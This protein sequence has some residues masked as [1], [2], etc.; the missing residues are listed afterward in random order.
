MEL[1]HLRYFCVV[2]EEL[3]LTCAAERLHTPDM[4]VR[5]YHDARLAE[6]R[7][8]AE[9][10]VDVVPAAVCRL[11]D[12]LRGELDRRWARNMLLNKWLEYCTERGHRFGSRLWSRKSPT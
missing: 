8:C 1:R 2:A 10:R 12:S 11:H 3:N 6:A 7:S 4:Q 9:P 5:V